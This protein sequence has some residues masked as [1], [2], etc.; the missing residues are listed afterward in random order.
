[1]EAEVEKKEPRADVI[2]RIFERIDRLQAI[3][4]LGQEGDIMI[5][6]EEAATIA[7]VEP[8]TILSWG[9]NAVIP[10]Y[11]LGAAVRFGLR[12]FCEWVASCRQPAIT[13]TRKKV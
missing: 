4:P 7:C 10:R 2:N 1:M 6:V 3:G 11:K 8:N 5:N 13:E 9:Q 12:E